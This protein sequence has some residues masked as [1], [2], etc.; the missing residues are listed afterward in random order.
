MFPHPVSRIAS[1][2]STFNLQLATGLLR[3]PATLRHTTPHSDTINLMQATPS[4]TD[5]LETGSGQAG[6]CESQAHLFKLGHYQQNR[7]LAFAPV[8]AKLQS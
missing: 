8:F 1:V 3:K 5:S 2:L 7:I 4:N 6:S